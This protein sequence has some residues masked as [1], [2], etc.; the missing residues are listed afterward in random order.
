MKEN[1]LK[2]AVAPFSITADDKRVMFENAKAFN[3][4]R[5]LYK[6]TID[7][8]GPTPQNRNIRN[9]GMEK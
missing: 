2:L 3:L 7:K 8:L 5:V 6:E 1:T 4:D 9:I